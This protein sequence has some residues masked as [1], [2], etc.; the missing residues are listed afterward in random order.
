MFGRNK[1]TSATETAAVE[2][3]VETA[4]EQDSPSTPGYTVPKGRPTPSRK[5]REAARRNPLVPQDRKAAKEAQK[6]AD[7]EFRA[8]QQQALQTGDEKY[9]PVNDR[10]PQRRFIR[11]YVDARL[12]VGDYMLPVFLLIFAVGLFLPGVYQSYVM[13]GMWVLIILWMVDCWILWRK[14]KVQLQEKFG[15]IEP[16]SGFYTFNRAMM[17]RRFRLPKPQVKRGDYPA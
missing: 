5:E 17:I 12:N 8:K 16:R 11:D 1:K 14:V 10:G 6:E 2:Q 7:R 15:T 9:L 4:S 13:A 3:P